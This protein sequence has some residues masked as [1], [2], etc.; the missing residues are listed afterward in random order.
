MRPAGWEAKFDEPI[1]VSKGKPLAT[2]RDAAQYITELPKA[3]HDASEW[4]TAMHCLIEAA[5]NGGPIEFAR[6]SMMRGLNRHVE[7]VPG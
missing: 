5:D 3:D 4:Q 2:L 6:I 7:R 1:P